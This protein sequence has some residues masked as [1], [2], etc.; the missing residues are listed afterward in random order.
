[1]VRAF[2][3]LSLLLF[4]GQALLPIVHKVLVNHRVCAQHGEWVHV[5]PAVSTLHEA[6]R[7]GSYLLGEADHQHGHCDA[8]VGTHE[9]PSLAAR[10][11]TTAPV[12][13]RPAGVDVLSGGEFSIS[14]IHRYRIA[15]KQGPPGRS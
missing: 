12:L 13:L 14:G 1:V 15:P 8:C 9:K 4:S 5:H 3:L 11:V 7:S 6:G 2:A 10:Q